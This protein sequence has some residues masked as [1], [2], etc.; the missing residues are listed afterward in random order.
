[1]TCSLLSKLD[2][3]HLDYNNPDCL[4]ADAD[5]ATSESGTRIS[6]GETEL[7]T[8]FTK[9]VD[10]SMNDDRSPNDGERTGQRELSVGDLHSRYSVG[11]GLHVAEITGVSNRIGGGA[12][13]LSVRIE[14]T[15]G[16]SAAVCVVS[17]LV[18]VEAVRAF[19]KTSQ[20]AFNSHWSADI[21]LS[22]VDGSLDD[23]ASQHANCLQRHLFDIESFYFKGI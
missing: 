7:V 19:R 16:G 21:G 23:F 14:V 11:A 6:G 8:S 18:N 15:S 3:N 1:M 10:V 5:H 4:L 2:S 22:E 12:V 17:K 9:V 20:F 13:R